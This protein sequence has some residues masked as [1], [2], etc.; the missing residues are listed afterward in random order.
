M[1]PGVQAAVNTVTMATP[2]LG[3][4]IGAIAFRSG[5]GSRMVINETRGRMTLLMLFLSGATVSA[6]IASGWEFTVN[7]RDRPEIKAEVILGSAAI[8]GA[9]AAIGG[10]LS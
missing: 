1:L 6:A 3:L 2:Y 5:V 4:G 7:S 9:S 8:G 10:F